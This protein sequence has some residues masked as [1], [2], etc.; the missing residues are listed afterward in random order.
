MS[1]E[2]TPTIKNLLI[3]ESP[4]KAKTIGKFLGK[5]FSVAASMGHIRDL[6]KNG[7]AVDIENGFI[8]QYVVPPEK[9]KVVAELKKLAQ[10]AEK[11]WLATD[12]DREGEAIS[13][14]LTQVLGLDPETTN[15]I[16]F[17]EIT[18]AAIQKAIAQPRKLDMDLV[19]AQQ[20]RRVL[21]RLVGFEISPL[22]WK[23]VKAGLSAGRVQ[24]VAVRL[25]VEREREIMNFKSTYQFK[26]Q[27]ELFTENNIPLKAELKE[28]FNESSEALTFL[29]HCIGATYKV[30]NLEV[31]PGKR[32]PP[33]PFT[34]STLQQEAARKLG[35]SVAQTMRL[36]Q[37]LY[38]NGHITYMRTDSVT[39]SEQA[40]DAIA[41]TIKTNFGAHYYQHRIYKT[42]VAN[43]QE[44][45]EA[46]RPTDFSQI[47]IPGLDSAE[48]KLYELIW[49]RTVASQMADAQIEKTIATIA[50]LPTNQEITLPQLVA[51]GEVIKFDGFLKLYIESK[52]ED[53]EDADSQALPPLLINQI[54]YLKKMTA[55]QR[56]T[57][58]PPRY[59]EAT[60]VKKL[61]EL[62]IGRPSTY[63][64]TISTIQKRQYVV[65]ESREGVKRAYQ[66]LTL[67]RDKITQEEKYE[68]TGTEKNKL[69]PTDL[70]MLVTDFLKLYFADIVDYSFTAKVEEEF[71]EIS[72][73]RLKW[74]QMLKNFYPP[75]HQKVE[76]TEQ[77]AERVAG[78]RIL[79][80]DPKTGKPV[81]ARLGKYGPLVQ[82][83]DS[84]DQDKKFASLLPGQHLETITLEEALALFEL[85]RKL[86]TFEDQEIVASIGRFGPY[87]RHGD[88]FISLGKELSPYT[89]T[90]EQAIEVILAKR[91]A[92]AEKVIRVFE[93]TPF[94][95]M[96]G[97][98][99]AYLSAEGNTIAL[100]KAMK[101]NPETITVE[102]CQKLYEEY[103]AS[104]KSKRK[105]KTVNKKEEISQSPSADNS[106][107]GEAKVK[108]TKTK[109]ATNNSSTENQEKK[110]A[111]NA[112][113]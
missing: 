33:A 77:N 44:A 89:I 108:K 12:E 91:K 100:P 5:D 6:P 10:Q 104:P 102:D 37:S 54:L 27:A 35:Y 21:D 15:R 110:K 97:R 29:N 8:P 81:I 46:I 42:K 17:H 11:V 65:K 52:D 96:K 55:T 53:E 75:F 92:D 38:E 40:L 83:G 71:D 95:L 79:G 49:K 30:V 113:K 87:I 66:V 72:H 63:A 59:T 19:E 94:S 112:K 3:V 68:T 98:W 109:K 107:S 9:T 101:Q 64:P 106:S 67:E 31:K 47:Q 20:A 2:N 80:A 85:P 61:E 70:G 84:E 7:K 90:Q 43:A 69:F 73:G 28:K 45:H 82:I 34:T 51:S 4:T 58:H 93:G 23:K 78:E 99:G 105:A 1:N 76:E 22:L 41:Q 16:V 56:F 60:L 26:V 103:L 36:A 62:G 57:K 48:Q 50:I 88:K 39:L 86:G 18:Q 111:K 25:I 13:W 24:S 74:N 32:T 14:H